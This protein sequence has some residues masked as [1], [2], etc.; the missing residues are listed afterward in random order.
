M[1]YPSK[2]KARKLLY[3]EAIRTHPRRV[4]VEITNFLIKT[5]HKTSTTTPAIEIK[6]SVKKAFSLLY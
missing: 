6:L 2:R 5:A 4:A 1:T 3:T